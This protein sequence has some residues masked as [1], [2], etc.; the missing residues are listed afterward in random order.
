M[1]RH[2]GHLIRPRQVIIGDKGFSGGQIETFITNKL[3]AE[4][5]RPD[6]RDEKPR[7]GKL[8]NIRPWFEFGFDAMKGQL[9]LDGRGGRT[10]PGFYSRVAGRLFTL[11][12]AIWYNWLIGEPYKRPLIVHEYKDPPN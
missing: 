2:D 11:A 5:I 12:A 6:R 8:G 4:L 10:I 1:L 9:T 3:D 7:F